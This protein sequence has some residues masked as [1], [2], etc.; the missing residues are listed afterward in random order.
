MTDSAFEVLRCKALAMIDNATLPAT[1]P[2]GDNR[3]QGTVSSLLCGVGLK[4]FKD[5]RYIISGP[6]KTLAGTQQ[7][8]LCFPC[9]AAWQR[10]V[11]AG[12]NEV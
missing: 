3:T 9:H 12:M 11:I 5:F 4:Q 7:Y 10:A 8:I 1:I 6:G 2:E